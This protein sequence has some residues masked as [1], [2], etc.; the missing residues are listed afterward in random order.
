MC[1]V[2]VL[3]RAFAML[4]MSNKYKSPLKNFLNDFSKKAMKFDEKD[5]EMRAKLFNEFWM[6]CGDLSNE[7]FKNEKKKFVISF[8]EA[9]FVAV[10]EKIKSEG[11]NGRKITEESL[12]RLK[13]DSAF[14]EAAQGS[15]A[16]TTSVTMRLQRAREI[17]ELQ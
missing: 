3:V 7:V 11:L 4:D 6:S 1:E 13:K 10:C 5:I 16:S 12:N 2:E 15:T 17:I 14:A 8:F 9:V